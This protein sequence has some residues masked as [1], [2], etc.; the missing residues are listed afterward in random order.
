MSKHTTA[1]AFCLAWVLWSQMEKYDGQPSRW[2]RE[3]AA[4][5]RDECHKLLSG[6]CQS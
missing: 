4:D 2:S 1:I 5:T 3:D 6:A